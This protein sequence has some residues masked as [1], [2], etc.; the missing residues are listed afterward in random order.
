MLKVLNL[1]EVISKY[2][3]RYNVINDSQLFLH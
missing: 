1:T 3:F 2:N